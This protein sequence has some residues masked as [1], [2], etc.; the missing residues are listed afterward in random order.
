M[1]YEQSFRAKA[2]AYL[3]SQGENISQQGLKDNVLALA[4]LRYL[5]IKP[6]TKGK[7]KNQVTKLRTQ[8]IEALGVKPV[9]GRGIRPRPVSMW[10]PRPFDADHVVIPLR[11]KPTQQQIDKFYASWEWKR[12]RYDFIKDKDRRCGCCG[13]TPE[14]GARIVVDHVKPIRL[15]W[16]LR[17]DKKN[18]QLL[19]DDCNMGKGSRDQTDWRESAG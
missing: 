15:F 10:D 12:L 6:R 17:L 19:C 18:L 8:V 3:A 9:D 11:S 13:A 16:G 4:V 7:K 1:S 14:D 2:L 5:G